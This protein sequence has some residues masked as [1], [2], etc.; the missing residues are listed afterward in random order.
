[1]NFNSVGNMFL[2]SA[3]NLSTWDMV[4]I[5]FTLLTGVCVFLF[6]MKVMGD[7]L[8]RRAGN[9]LK[10]VLGR[11]TSNKFLGFLTGFFSY[12]RNTK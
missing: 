12:V 10:S 6:G 8:E 9:A 11:L 7:G 5:V 2:T 3:T 1:M 4:M